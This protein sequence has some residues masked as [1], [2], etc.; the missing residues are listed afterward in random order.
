MEEIDKSAISWLHGLQEFFKFQNDE[1]SSNYVDFILKL[2]YANNPAIT[3]TEEADIVEFI[4]TLRKFA[5]NNIF[6]AFHKY[7]REE[8]NPKH[9]QDAFSRGQVQS[10]IWLVTELAKIKNSF[11]NTLILAGWYGQLL[12][13]FNDIQ[14]DS[15]RIVELDRIACLISDTIINL[16]LIQDYRV[17]AVHGDINNLILNK[18]GYEFEIE[19]FKNAEQK[20]YIDKFLPDLIIN[21]SA[22]HMSEKWFNDIRFKDFETKPL[23]VIQSNNLFDV[24]EHINC[25]HSID[26]MKKNYPMSEI[27]YEGELQ[28][29]GY[30]RIMLIGLP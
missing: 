7:Y 9:L 25:V 15:V 21:T 1:I 8:H 17:K 29:K 20:K 6:N 2:L 16:D 22:E 19:N 4:G 26:H 18:K 5:D 27:F 28:L 30:K 11:S 10:K 14:F 12:R 3:I 23:V 24:E 13:Y